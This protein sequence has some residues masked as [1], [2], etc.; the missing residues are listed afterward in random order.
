VFA[1]VVFKESGKSDISAIIR[2]PDGLAI[3]IIQIS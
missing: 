3:E 1:S 2:D